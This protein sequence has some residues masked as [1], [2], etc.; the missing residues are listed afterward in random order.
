MT[1]LKL[2]DFKPFTETR[3]RELL[4]SI[5]KTGMITFNSNATADLIGDKEN[6]QLLHHEDEDYHYIAFKFQKRNGEGWLP[7]RNLKPTEIK[8]RSGKKVSVRPRASLTC[9]RFFNKHHID[10]Q[11]IAGKFYIEFLK[12]GSTKVPFIKIP[13]RAE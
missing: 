3:E 10:V 11:K 7:I 1:D 4:L 5:S 9:K 12:E 8:D 2:S 13:K 6:V